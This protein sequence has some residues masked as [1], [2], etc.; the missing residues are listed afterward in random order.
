MSL[1][2]YPENLSKSVPNF[3]SNVADKQT[4]ATENITSLARVMNINI[5][6]LNNDQGWQ[7]DFT[8]IIVRH[9]KMLRMLNDFAIF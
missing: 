3:L 1:P 9:W 4:S 8:M 7:V 2:S 5:A 6:T